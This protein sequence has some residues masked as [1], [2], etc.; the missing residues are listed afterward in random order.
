MYSPFAICRAKSNKNDKTYWKGQIELY[1]RKYT[2]I[3]YLNEEGTII[4]TSLTPHR[5][6]YY[7]RNYRR[8][9]GAF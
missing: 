1:G 4:R 2:V 9:N 7:N 5:R 6:R 8:S 3:N